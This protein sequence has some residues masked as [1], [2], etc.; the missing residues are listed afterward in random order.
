MNTMLGFFLTLASF[1]TFCDAYC[2]SKPL[3]LEGEELPKGCRDSNGVMHD[4]NTHWQY[5]CTSCSCDSRAGLSCCSMVMK[6]HGYDKDKCQ[7]IFNK[8]KC[9]ISVVEKA[10]PTVPCEVPAYVG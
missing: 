3:Q 10:D 9:T 6:P 4:F 7:E 5:D 8:E 2:M 1:L